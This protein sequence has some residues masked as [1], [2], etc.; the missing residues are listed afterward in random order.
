MQ[1]E[2]SP[3]VTTE[4]GLA[5][6]VEAALPVL[7]LHDSF[8]QHR[9]I[10][11]LMCSSKALRAA[12]HK[13]YVLVPVEV[14]LI[15]IE[16]ARHLADFLSRNGHIVSNLTLTYSDRDAEAALAAGLQRATSGKACLKLHSFRNAVQGS[17][18][19]LLQAVCSTSLS[20]LSLSFAAA[21]GATDTSSVAQAVAALTNL[22]SLELDN[23]VE[24]TDTSVT[25]FI[26]ALSALQQLT[27]LKLGF[28]EQLDK[29]QHLPGHLQSLTIRT[30]G[31]HNSL[32][33]IQLQHLTAL[34]RLVISI[35]K[36]TDTSLRQHD[37]YP[38][39][40]RVLSL[41]LDVP[42]LQQLVPLTKLQVLEVHHA[43]RDSRDLTELRKC[44]VSL[45]Q[46]KLHYVPVV[47]TP[48][49]L[50]A[51]D[52][53]VSAAAAGWAEVPLAALSFTTWS[54]GA[55]TIQQLGKLQGLTMLS[56]AAGSLD[57]TPQQLAQQLSKLTGLQQLTLGWFALLPQTRNPTAL[58]TSTAAEDASRATEETDCS[59]AAAATAVDASTLATAGLVRVIASLPKLT[60]LTFSRLQLPGLGATAVTELVT[61]TRLHSLTLTACELTDQALAAVLGGISALKRL[62]VEK[63]TSITDWSLQAI[64]QLP[65]LECLNVRQTSVTGTALLS[66]KRQVLQRLP[67]CQV[68]HWGGPVG[69]QAAG[70]LGGSL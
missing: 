5:E 39:N 58:G 12:L 6:A 31:H 32:H 62:D 28:S 3:A 35:D 42:S 43:V 17:S 70:W 9:T 54:A 30:I 24:E 52:A 64:A 10:C 27:E 57:V 7:L 61:A 1:D 47:D 26:P 23:W 29:W 20:R 55:T 46:M 51:A 15:S 25:Q 16:Q 38:V 33:T 37:Q 45:Q 8:R 65:A 69:Q 11:S 63:N 19:A 41:D 48:E 14:S 34:S 59:T 67:H 21:R 40:L 13:Y 50:L 36:R 60:E 68:L 22:R 49:A 53:T 2:Q 56:I 4:S 44:Q 18:A 66:F